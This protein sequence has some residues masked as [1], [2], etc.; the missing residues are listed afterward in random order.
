MPYA[1]GSNYSIVWRIILVPFLFMTGQEPKPCVRF[2]LKCKKIVM[3]DI[4]IELE[5][6]FLRNLEI[7]ALVKMGHRRLRLNEDKNSLKYRKPGIGQGWRNFKNV[8]RWRLVIWQNFLIFTSIW[9]KIT[10]N[11]N[12]FKGEIKKFCQIT[13]GQRGTFLK[14]CQ[15]W[16]M[17]G[18]K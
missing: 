2:S 12:R 10:G 16:P 5:Q 15:P 1:V 11:G 4:K 18:H 17:T 13:V 14:L 7:L 8:P 6:N 3:F 9:V